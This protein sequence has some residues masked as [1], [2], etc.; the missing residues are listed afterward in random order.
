MPIADINGVAL[1]LVLSSADFLRLKA[2]FLGS[3]QVKKPSSKSRAKLFFVTRPDQYFF[4]DA[5]ADIFYQS[6]SLS[7][8]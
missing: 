7:R 4:L 6:R 3:L 8:N 5:I 1:R 2:I